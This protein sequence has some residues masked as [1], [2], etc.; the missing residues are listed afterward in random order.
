MSE[1]VSGPE[2]LY[3]FFRASHGAN[4]PATGFW[5]FRPLLLFTQGR[6]ARPILSCL[7]A[8]TGEQALKRLM[9]VCLSFSFFQTSPCLQYFPFHRS[10]PFLP[11]FPF[12]LTSPV[13]QVLSVPPGLPAPPVL[14]VPPPHF[15]LSASRSC[16]KAALPARHTPLS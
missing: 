5:F 6:L 15:L 7:P 10:S 2:G 4:W 9:P 8:V 13:P 14:S 16:D 11:P 1:G 12:R 3:A